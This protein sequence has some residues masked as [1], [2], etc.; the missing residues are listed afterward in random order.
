VKEGLARQALFP[1]AARK[2]HANH[3]PRE[4]ILPYFQQRKP[5]KTNNKTNRG[6]RPAVE[7]LSFASPKESTQRKA[8]RS[9]SNSRPSHPAQGAAELHRASVT[10]LKQQPLN[11]LGGT[12]AS[13]RADGGGATLSLLLQLASCCY[14]MLFLLLI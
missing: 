14:H 1:S 6:S 8:T 4:R 13:A 3:H 9:A 12:S 10:V 7:V 5:K 11:T 2:R